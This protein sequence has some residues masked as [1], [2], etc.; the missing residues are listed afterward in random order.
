MKKLSKLLAIIT[1]FVLSVFISLLF[2]ELIL[3]FIYPQ[4]PSIQIEYK[5][6]ELDKTHGQQGIPDDD[7][8]VWTDH[9]LRLRPNT[10]AT[11]FS[12]GL[13]HK[14]V[15][16]VTNSLGFRH[17]EL[18]EK[19]ENERR[20]LVLGDSITLGD[21]ADEKDTYPYIIEHQLQ[22]R[23]PSSQIRVMNAGVASIDL[24]TEM[25]I[26]F[27]TGLKSKP[28]VVLIGLYLN[29]AILSPSMKVSSL[30][31][32]ANNSYLAYYTNLFINKKITFDFSEVSGDLLNSQKEAFIQKSSV[33]ADL[34][35]KDHQEGFNSLVVENFGDWGYAWS[36]DYWDKIKHTL[37]LINTE[38]ESR[39]IKLA[40]A[41]FPVRYQVEANFATDYPQQRFENLMNEM[42]LPHIDLLPTLRDKYR[43]TNTE[44]YYDHCHYQPEG[45]K[46]VGDKIA[47]FLESQV[48]EKNGK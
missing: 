44:Y 48:F 25:T 43:E 4:P 17:E 13:G 24:N 32:W 46:I 45:N 9:G 36:D 27:D 5:Q 41:Y 6:P 39:N 20:I 15:S 12:D 23:F 29:D 37:T 42:N 3:R 38:L 8:Y 7:L 10:K 34:D 47:D 33:N 16:I 31:K 22:N 35:W 30:P 19:K 1:I 18:Q 2:C 28:D 21:Y 26:L 11:R 14:N 40:V